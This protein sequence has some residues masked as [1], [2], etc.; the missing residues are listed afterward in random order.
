MPILSLRAGFLP[1]GR[2]RLHAAFPLGIGVN[3]K[4]TTNGFVFHVDIVAHMFCSVNTFYWTLR[5][6]WFL[7]SFRR[8]ELN[9]KGSGFLLLLMV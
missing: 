7:R 2:V 4:C 6:T 3:Y 5:L 8:D 9:F 1:D